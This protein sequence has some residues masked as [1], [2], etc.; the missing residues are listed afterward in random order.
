MEN[1]IL[2]SAFKIPMK[3]YNPIQTLALR[4]R[5]SWSEQNPS[6]KKRGHLK[7]KMKQKEKLSGHLCFRRSY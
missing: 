6:N 2:Y 5:I 7:T 1:Y 3:E 4:S